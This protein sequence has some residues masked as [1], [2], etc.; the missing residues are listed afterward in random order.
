MDEGVPDPPPG[1]QKP[2]EPITA[3]SWLDLLP[4]EVSLFVGAVGLFGGLTGILHDTSA[5]VGVVWRGVLL[6][7]WAA[8]STYLVLVATVSS[9]IV[10]H[11]GIHMI[12][13]RL[14]GCNARLERDGI[15]V[16]VRLHG[17]FLSRHADALI[18]L[19]PA[20]ALT[21]AGLPLLV[22]VESAFGVTIMTTAL[23]M[24]VAGSGKDIA[25]V[26]VLRQLPPGS[27][28]YYSDTQLV[29]EPSPVR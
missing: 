26:L 8:L 16:R 10:L 21:V 12:T 3:I 24:N 2:R 23:V 13:A 22:I 5:V 29:Y 17:D 1:Y 7:S 18:S 28:L 25:S 19:A 11:E 15:R 4:G 27:R 14:F 9:T 6:D 20:L